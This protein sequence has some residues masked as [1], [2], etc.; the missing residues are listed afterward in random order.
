MNAIYPFNLYRKWR[1]RWSDWNLPIRIH[2]CVRTYNL[3]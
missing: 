3:L 2:C 1:Q